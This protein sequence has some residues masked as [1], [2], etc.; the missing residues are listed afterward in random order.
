MFSF[1]HTRNQRGRVALNLHNCTGVGAGLQ[2][3]RLLL[4]SVRRVL[5]DLVSR[6]RLP[7][8]PRACGPVGLSRPFLHDAL[9]YTQVKVSV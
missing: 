2:T 4:R 5:L 7:F 3:Q 6:R 9:T 8:L 1:C